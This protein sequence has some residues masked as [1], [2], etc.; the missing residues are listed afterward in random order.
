MHEK[1]VNLLVF[2]I[3]HGVYILYLHPS[4]NQLINSLSP[5]QVSRPRENATMYGITCGHICFHWKLRVTYM[6]GND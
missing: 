5:P 1:M 3:T 4:M 6:N 2:F